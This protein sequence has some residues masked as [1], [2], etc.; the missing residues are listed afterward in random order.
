[1]GFKKRCRY[2]KVGSITDHRRRQR[3]SV[4]G[5]KSTFVLKLAFPQ[6]LL[7]RFTYHSTRNGARNPMVTKVSF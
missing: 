5:A 7:T 4:G 1:M 6:S 3:F 2:G